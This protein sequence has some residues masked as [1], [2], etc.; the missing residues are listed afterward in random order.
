MH[1]RGA[2]VF[3]NLGIEV[4]T[5]DANTVVFRLQKPYAPFLS[6]MTVFDAPILPRHLYEGSNIGTNPV[7]QRPVHRAV[8]VRRMETRRNHGTQRSV[9][10]RPGQALPGADRVP[11]HPPGAQP[12]AGTAG[13]RD[14]R[15]ARL[16]HPELRCRAWL[17]TSTVRPP[18][19][20]HPGHLVY[21]V[22]HQGRCLHQQ[23]RPPCA[24]H[25]PPAHRQA[26]DAGYCAA[27]CRC[28]WRR[29]QVDAERRGGLRQE[30]PRR[31]GPRP[32]TAGQ[33]GIK[34]NTTTVRIPFDVGRPQM[35]AQSQIIQDNLRQIG[36]K[37]AS[38]RWSVRCCSSGCT[39]NATST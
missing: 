9:L 13:G 11:D 6:Q 16:L 8:Q 38:S 19:R 27:G 25:P 17:P 26:G 20:E 4:D 18:R 5:P 31:P 29:F 39:P 35:R 33:A 36:C 28:F 2:P 1:P 32:H 22:Q 10:G 30:V 15:A 12:R 34:P 21:D 37:R 3:K 14:R 7:N 24:G 23:G